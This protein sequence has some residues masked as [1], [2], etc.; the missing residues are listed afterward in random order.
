[1]AKHV[2]KIKMLARLEYVL[3]AMQRHNT[4]YSQNVGQ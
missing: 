1:M 4:S 2:E 3:P